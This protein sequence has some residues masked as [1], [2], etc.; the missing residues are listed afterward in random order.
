VVAAFFNSSVKNVVMIDELLQ[1]AVPG[2]T[3]DSA[4]GAKGSLGL[5]ESTSFLNRFVVIFLLFS[6]SSGSI[7]ASFPS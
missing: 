4:T 3:F 2:K 7:F 1:A 5:P 6:L